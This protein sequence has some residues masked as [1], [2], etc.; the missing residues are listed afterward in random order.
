M[1]Y[2]LCCSS[3]LFSPTLY[4]PV[5]AKSLTTYAYARVESLGVNLYEFPQKSIVDNAM[6]EIPQ[7]YFVLLLSNYN[8]AFYKAQYL[9][10]VGYVLKSEVFPVSNTPNRPYLNDL[11]FWVFS[12]DGR[13]MQ[14]APTRNSSVVTTLSLHE[15][16]SYYGELQGEEMVAGRGATWYYGKVGENYGYVYAGLCDTSSNFT[17]N[18][19]PVTYITNP[20]VDS[21]DY[22]Y[23]LVDMTSNLKILVLFLLVV[24]ALLLVYLLFKPFKLEQDPKKIK[25][26]SRVQTIKQIQ[27]F[28]D[29]TI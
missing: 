8:D 5:L 22:L 19:E 14:S 16:V 1:F 15:R 3:V 21:N 12:S 2:I 17:E 9:G 24:P 29:D 10:V 26:H 27:D 7:S 11:T 4:T 6:F 13:S 25:R 18:T 23:S 28:Y 20:F